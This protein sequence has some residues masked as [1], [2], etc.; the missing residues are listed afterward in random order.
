MSDKKDIIFSWSSGKDSAYALYQILR[1]DQYRVRALLTTFNQKY[2]RVSMHGVRRDLVRRQADSLGIFLEEVFIP[3]NCSGDKY[4]EIMSS[5]LKKYKNQAVD[6][7]AFGDLFLDDVKVY[8]EKQLSRLSMKAVFPLWNRNTSELITDFLKDGFKAVL[9]CVDTEQL[10]AEFCGRELNAALIKSFPET[11]DPCG[12]KG[13]FHS[14]I[15][16]G[17]IFKEPISYFCGEK[18]LRDKRFLF[19]DLV[20]AGEV[21]PSLTDH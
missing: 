18:T 17:P 6:T 10:S 12:E 16:D 19:T 8:R 21:K 1:S 2:D 5:V 7:V 9:T 13:E 14:F 4:S 3:D 11:A 15:F 20:F